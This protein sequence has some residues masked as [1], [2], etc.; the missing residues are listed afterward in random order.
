ML[1]F[2][3]WDPPKPKTKEPFDVLRLQARRGR[4]YIGSWTAPAASRMGFRS[5]VGR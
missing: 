4:G 2:G 3:P 1:I 5:V